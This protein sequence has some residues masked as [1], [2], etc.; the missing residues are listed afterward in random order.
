LTGFDSPG[1]EQPTTPRI[2]RLSDLI[3]GLALSIS[4]LTLVGQQPATNEQLG[5]SLGL[6]GFSFLILIGVWRVY[7]SVSSMLLSETSFLVDLNIALLFLVSVEPYLFNELFTVQGPMSANV[8]GMYS[9]DLAGMFFIMAYFDHSLAREEKH[10]VPIELLEK[11]RSARNFRLLIAGVFL[12]SILPFFGET[13]LF[14]SITGDKTYDFTLRSFMWLL[15]L[16]LVWGRRAF[17]TVRGR[18]VKVVAS[19]AQAA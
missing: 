19:P 2:Q 3:F 5:F 6:Y 4:A 15:G 9:L 16:F 14:T 17:T 10:L 12:V 8:T 13:V 11:H 18:Q 1:S 7:S